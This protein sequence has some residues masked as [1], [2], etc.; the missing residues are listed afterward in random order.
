MTEKNLNTIVLVI[1]TDSPSKVYDITY[2]NFDNLLTEDVDEKFL[3]LLL[4]KDFY[5][6]EVYDYLNNFN[7]LYVNI[8]LLKQLLEDNEVELTLIESPSFISCE[9]VTLD[10]I[11]RKHSNTKCITERLFIKIDEFLKFIKEIHGFKYLCDFEKNIRKKLIFLNDNLDKVCN[12]K[13]TFIEEFPE[14]ILKSEMLY[15]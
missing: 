6:I 4:G 9:Y 2:K 11:S 5:K 7:N 8:K 15:N 3:K 1:E 10:I 12:L 13:N 14:E